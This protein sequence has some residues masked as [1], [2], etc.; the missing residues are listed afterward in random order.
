MLLEI[1]TV[2]FRLEGCRSLKDKRR[3]LVGLRHRFGRATNVAVCESNYHDV[4]DR[5]EWTFVVTGTDQTIVERTLSHIEDRIENN[6][7]AI[8]MGF[9]RESL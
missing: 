3:R 4:H 5:S 2:E 8:V 1:L 7:D 9:E 6:V